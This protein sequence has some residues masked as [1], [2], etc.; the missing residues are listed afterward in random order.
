MKKSTLIAGVLMG[1]TAF[2]QV[3]RMNRMNS[4]ALAAQADTDRLLKI[5]KLGGIGLDTPA[6]Q[7]HLPAGCG[8][9]K[10]SAETK[11]GADG[12]YHQ[13]WSYPACGLELGMSATRPKGAQTLHSIT[14]TAPG[15]LRTRRNIG[16]GSP[17]AEVMKA[18]AKEYSA[19]ESQ[20][21]QTIVAGSIYGGI[22]FRID[23]GKVSRI[24]FGAAAE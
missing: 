9:A 11:W 5:D 7:L 12:L 8:A 13:S 4:N 21:G 3:N 22:I 19:D 10:K 14:L 15:K 20:A 24:F 2:A 18:Y 1:M 23:G 6:A 16:I 17:A